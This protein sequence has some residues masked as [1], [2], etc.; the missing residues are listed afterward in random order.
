MQLFEGLGFEGMASGLIDQE[1]HLPWLHF[2]RQQ[3][4]F[5]D[6]RHTDE[7]QL[8][9]FH[10]YSLDTLFETP[11]ARRDSA[12]LLLS[13]NAVFPECDN[14]LLRSLIEHN[15]RAAA[16]VALRSDG[17]SEDLVTSIGGQRESFH[18]IRRFM[19][20]KDDDKF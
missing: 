15:P 7:I 9:E 11:F 10:M 13:H 19:P 16:K 8:P 17:Q 5:E 3:H 2:E 14:L 20:R 6:D 18:Q 1:N 4:L 12:T